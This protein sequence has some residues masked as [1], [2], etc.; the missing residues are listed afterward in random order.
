MHSEKNLLL[1]TLKLLRHFKT[2]KVLTIAD[3][4]IFW[5]GA[6]G[7]CGVVRCEMFKHE[8]TYLC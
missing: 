4:F 3:C 2:L 7:V 1:F 8:P 6:G 5:V